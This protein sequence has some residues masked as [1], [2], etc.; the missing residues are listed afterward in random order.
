[1]IRRFASPA[2][3]KRSLEERLRSV[4]EAQQR[5]LN[6]VRLNLVLERF[7][8]RLFAEPHPFWLLKGGF[9]LE[10]R[11]RPHARTTKDIDLGM[12]EMTAVSAAAATTLHEQLKRAA[13]RDLGDFLT[14]TVAAPRSLRGVARATTRFPCQATLAAKLYSRF[15]VDVGLGDPLTEPPEQLVGAPWLDFAGVPPAIVLAVP[16]AQQFAEKIHAYT[17]PRSDRPNTR[18]KDLV[19]LVRLIESPWL[20]VKRVRLALHATFDNRNSHPLP[21]ELPPPPPAWAPEYGA[22]AAQ[23]NLKATTLERGFDRLRTLWL[24]QALGV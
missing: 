8:A 3:F 23:A 1:M 15:H 12:N 2:D 9:A 19:D 5:D 20:E 22:L 14:F 6:S 11:F 13:E 21:A 17:L 24:D 10:L 18:M 4:A 16:V 7:L